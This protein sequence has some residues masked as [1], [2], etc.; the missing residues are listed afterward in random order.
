MANNR[1]YIKCK[2][3]GDIFF[4]AKYYPTT[5][6]YTDKDYFNGDFIDSFNGWLD[7]HRHDDGNLFGENQY[8]IAYEIK[9]SVKEKIL[10][11]IKKVINYKKIKCYECGKIIRKKDAFPVKTIIP[12]Y[13]FGCIDTEWYCSLHKKPYTQVIYPPDGA[14]TFL[15]N[16]GKIWKP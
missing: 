2:K 16:T 15:D 9:P 10:D 5:G 11:I 12:P 8:E 14:A 3:D 4:L 1:M 6:Y 7:K 13:K